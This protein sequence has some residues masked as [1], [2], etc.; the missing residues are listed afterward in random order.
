MVIWKKWDIE[1]FRDKRKIVSIWLPAV[2]LLSYNFFQVVFHECIFVA[3]QY[4]LLVAYS[5]A[6]IVY[7]ELI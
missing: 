7:L 3:K 1:V 2:M 4:D 6:Y 5:K